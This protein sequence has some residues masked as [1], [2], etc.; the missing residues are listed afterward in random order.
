MAGDGDDANAGAL[1][2]APERPQ[3][4]PELGCGRLDD[5]TLAGSSEP[6]ELPGGTVLVW[7]NV[8]EN[9]PHDPLTRPTAPPDARVA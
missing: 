3:V 9:G 5:G 1:R 8:A 2:E 4:P 6:S 7:L